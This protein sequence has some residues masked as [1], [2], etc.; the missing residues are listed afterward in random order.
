MLAKEHKSDLSR[1]LN[2]HQERIDF[3]LDQIHRMTR[4][5]RV[6]QVVLRLG[7][8]DGLIQAL[9][10]L[11]DDAEAAA[12][13]AADPRGYAQSKGIAVPED[14]IVG[15]QQEEGGFKVVA[16]YEDGEYSFEMSYDTTTGFAA[17]PLGERGLPA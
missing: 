5:I 10:E 6:H 1:Q 16:H 11:T 8:D 7:Q 3:L 12:Q 15:F 13:A 2:A 9:G 17:R 14:V 4:E